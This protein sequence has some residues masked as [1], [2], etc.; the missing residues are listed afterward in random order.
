VGGSISLDRSDLFH[1]VNFLEGSCRGIEF[2]RA[3]RN[4]PDARVTRGTG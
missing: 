4:K 1:D 3:W 2:A